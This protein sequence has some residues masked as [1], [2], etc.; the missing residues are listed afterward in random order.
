M[1]DVITFSCPQCDMPYRVAVANAGRNF[2]CK[3]CNTNVRVPAQS[4]PSAPV[5]MPA[6]ETEVLMDQGAQVIRK[7]DSAR[8][9]TVDPTRM[10]TRNSGRLLGASGAPAGPAPATPAAASKSKTPLIVA[11]VLLVVLLGGVGLAAAMGAFSSH[12]APGPV[13]GGNENGNSPSGQPKAETGEREKILAE[14]A[15]PSRTGPGMI[16]LYTRAINAKLSV[17]DLAA[18][19][20]DAVDRIH[21]ENGQDLDDNAILDFGELLQAHEMGGEAQRLYLLVA[22]RHKD[23]TDAPPSLLRAQK[24]RKLEKVDFAA[25]LALADDVVLSGLVDG[26]EPLR[27]ELAKLQQES[28]NGWA[29][30][31]AAARVAEIEAE[32]KKH[33]AEIER[34]GR[35]QP[36]R[37]VAATAI[38]QF[39]T[40][41]A[42]TR[43]SWGIEVHQPLIIYY[44]R[45]KNE[46]DSTALNRCLPAIQG[47]SQFIEFF[48]REWIEPMGLK[49][50]LPTDLA[51]TER[52]SAP[53]EI[54]LFEERQNWRA[55]LSD[56]RITGVDTTR[57]SMHIDQGRGRLTLLLAEGDTGVV[58]AMTQMTA[59]CIEAW[60]PRARETRNLPSF[61][62]YAIEVIL[63][64]A[65]SLC[66]R[67]PDGS[68]TTFEFFYPD[69][70]WVRV[71]HKWRQPFAVD[72]QGSIDSFGGPGMR[73]KDLVS[74]KG[75]RDFTDRFMANIGKYTGW[76][77]EQSDRVEQ[78][79]RDPGGRLLGTI[80][81]P[82][83]RA[84][85]MFLWHYEKDGKPRYR[86]AFRR[87]LVMDLEGKVTADNQLE[88]FTEAFGLDEAGW[89]TIEREFEEYQSP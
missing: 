12:N 47:L 80:L 52:Q 83:L 70:R 85:A 64:A 19:A 77:K 10:I 81:E 33:K 45:G 71:L 36:F 54:L 84:F 34:I 28:D 15:A 48:Q 79:L 57:E 60:H 75:P 59:F 73:L 25:A 17:L 31:V 14:A 74:M 16:K 30:G 40:Q 24:L 46:T 56:N 53:V 35:D 78:G 43:G 50:S 13:A 9:A 87:Y 21:N 76:T 32:L 18:I 69:R 72:A 68:D 5:I 49:R 38:R 42:A 20:T 55:Y 86:D 11:A 51:E 4:T 41:K 62:T 44:E 23:K 63:A 29:T 8:R 37:V 82:Y 6:P 58:Q 2:V 3:N 39:K 66:R 89:K 67:T 65:I 27:A 22:R 1:A 61:K 88:K 7:T 26:T